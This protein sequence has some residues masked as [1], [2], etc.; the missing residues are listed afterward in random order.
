LTSR[1]FPD[2]RYSVAN[3]E[4]EAISNLQ[5]LDERSQQDE[6]TTTV[7]NSDS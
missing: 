5:E 2:T 3:I 6:V 4:V 1:V 7:L